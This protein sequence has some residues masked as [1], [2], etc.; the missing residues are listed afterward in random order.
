MTYIPLKQ[1]LTPPINPTINSLGQLGNAHVCFNDL[2][3]HQ[4][5]HHWLRVH[6]CME[7][8]IIVTYQHLG[9]LYA[10]FKLLIPHMRHALAINAMAR[11]SLISAEGII[12]CSFTP[13]KYSTEMAC[14]AYR[15]WWRPE[16]LPEYLIRR[17]NGST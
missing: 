3:V 8:F 5:I 11:E 1:V 14:V 17:G 15:D 12:E 7:P 16:G 4:L 6:A 13:G 9:S 10:V 2:G